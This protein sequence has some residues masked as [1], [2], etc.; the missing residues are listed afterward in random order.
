MWSVS[1]NIL[2]LPQ[3][4]RANFLDRSK[5]QNKKNKSWKLAD[6]FGPAIRRLGDFLKTQIKNTFTEEKKRRDQMSDGVVVNYVFKSWTRLNTS[7]RN[8]LRKIIIWI[9][10]IITDVLLLL[11]DKQRRSSQQCRCLS[12]CS[13]WPRP[14]VCTAPDSL[15]NKGFT[16]SP[17]P[18]HSRQC[19]YRFYR[20]QFKTKTA[21]HM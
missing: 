5:L 2:V 4:Q 10:W 16:C 12:A 17:T 13:I 21:E 11:G 20:S 8:R 14:H 7:S 15:R 1:A 6:V 3:V 19:D 18:R 9:I